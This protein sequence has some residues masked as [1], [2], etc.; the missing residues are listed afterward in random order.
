MTYSPS[1]LQLTHV[2]QEIYRRLG[3]VVSTLTDGSDVL[4]V[5]AKLTDVL[6]EGNVDDFVNNGTLI[7][8]KTTDGA[9]PIGEFTVITD[10]DSSANAFTL[11]PAL[12]APLE[13]GDKV[14]YIGADFPLNDVIEVVNDALK[15]IGEIPVYDDTLTTADNTTEYDLPANVAGKEILDVQYATNSGLPDDNQF[16]PVEGFNP[17]NGR[18]VLPYLTGGYG[19]RIIYR[20]IH[21]R[22]E[23]FDD[24][25]SP[26]FNPELV[27]AAAFA[28]VVQ[29]KNDQNA[30]Q[31]A[32]DNSLIG[33]E[34]KA[35]S[36]YD[37]AR[38]MHPVAIP[39]RR[40]NNMPHFYTGWS[41]RRYGI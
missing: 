40:L 37:R 39:P 23:D 27:H 18:L 13:A 16:Y 31:G 30:V 33:L 25:I 15:Y 9:A 19:L 20:G 10:Y 38:I 36:Q 2:L 24:A 41:I 28:H 4:A 7:V 8:V 26:F 1:S 17:A 22:V 12:T 35:W 6:G 3:A 11:S 5:D 29:W 34:Q 14:L 21:S 32:A